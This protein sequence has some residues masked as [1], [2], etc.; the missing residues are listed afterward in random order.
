ML[1]HMTKVQIHSFGK[2]VILWNVIVLHIKCRS[3]NWPSN[4]S[5]SPSRSSD[6][7][8]S[9]IAKW[10]LMM[11]VDRIPLSWWRYAMGRF[12]H[13][14]PFDRIHW[15]SV[16]SPHKWQYGTLTLPLMLANVRCWTNQWSISC[17]DD[18]A[19]HKVSYPG[20]VQPKYQRG[21]LSA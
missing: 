1:K 17:F 12:P 14:W 20:I 3:L 7:R 21:W 18:M 10:T 2:G 19:T 6:V 15:P 4:M 5:L 16:D 13:Y 11:Y 8:V 9:F